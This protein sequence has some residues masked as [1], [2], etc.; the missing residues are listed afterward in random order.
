M[1]FYVNGEFVEDADATV[2]VTDRSFLYGDGCFEGIGICDGRVL[3]L[4]EHV[5]RMYRSARMLRIEMPVGPAE[6]RELILET[7]A[8]NG[9]AGGGMGY[10]RPLVSRGSG[11]L[12]LKFT[13][14]LGRATLVII[15]QVRDRVIAYQGDIPVLTAAVV[16]AVRASSASLEPRI[17]SNNYL[18]SIFAF[19]EARDRGADIGIMRDPQG[20][21]AEG[22]AM[23]LFCL[24][25]GRLL[26]PMESAA[27]GGITRANVIAQA[28]A[29][30]IECVE[31]NITAYDLRCA[32]EAF[33]TASLEGVA[34]LSAVDG[35]P[36][37]A[38][39]PGPVTTKVREAYVRFALETGVEIPAL[40]TA[41]DPA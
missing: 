6:L 21:L 5:A 9:L 3:H 38:P 31:T 26:T 22:Y 4:D 11:P 36:L 40:A 30:G 37:P 17:K 32:D 34:A 8:R 28:R 41:G 19:F 2:S 35:Q 27:L 1:W 23:N 10:V 39:V 33:V 15:P 12:G 20:F 29:L 7:A 14:D 16:S 18:P 25:D 24:R 13:G